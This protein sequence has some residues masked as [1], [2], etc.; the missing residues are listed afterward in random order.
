M[1]W[2]RARLL[3]PSISLD[4]SPRLVTVCLCRNEFTA[5]VLA[6]WC[7]HRL[8]K[9]R[10]P[11][12]W[13]TH[14]QFKVCAAHTG[15]AILHIACA[16]FVCVCAGVWH[17]DKCTSHDPQKCNRVDLI[18]IWHPDYDEFW[19]SYLKDDKSFFVKLLKL[20]SR[21]RNLQLPL[22]L[23]KTWYILTHTP[24]RWRRLGPR[25][26]RYCRPRGLCSAHQGPIRR[27][28]LSARNLPTKTGSGAI[29]PDTALPQGRNISARRLWW[30]SCY[31]QN[32]FT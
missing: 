23:I 24:S 26:N 18:K 27:L 30:I 5:A 25:W 3:P 2:I 6:L 28:S 32:V 21:P 15:A 9:G 7:A 14:I 13:T 10:S 19:Q 22:A 11:T 4:L 8:W 17:A 31:S 29:P 20:H 12:A 1:P 16:F